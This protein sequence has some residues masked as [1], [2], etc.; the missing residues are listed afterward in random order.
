MSGAGRL[1]GVSWV[2]VL[3]Q[4]LHMTDRASPVSG[5]GMLQNVSAVQH[6][7]G[8]HNTEPGMHTRYTADHMLLLVVECSLVCMWPLCSTSGVQ[9]WASCRLPAG[10][11]RRTGQ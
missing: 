9:Y 8:G 3:E 7:S 5:G 6:L 1:S 4:Q 2:E 10:A 11:N